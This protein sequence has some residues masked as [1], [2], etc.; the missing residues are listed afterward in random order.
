MLLGITGKKGSGKTT[1]ARIIQGI[2]AGYEFQ[3]LAWLIN[4]AEEDNTKLNFPSSPWREQA[5]SE[6]V[7]LVAA[8]LS[9]YRVE[10]FEDRE[11]K[12]KKLGPEWGYMTVRQLMQKVGE[13]IREGVCRDAWINALFLG[14]ESYQKKVFDHNF[15]VYTSVKK[16]PDWIISDV[17]HLN[18]AGAIR[19]IR[20]YGGCIIQ[21]L[22]NIDNKEDKA[23]SEVEVEKI[24]G[25]VYI[26]N[27][28]EPPMLDLVR[29]V[30]D[31]LH[32]IEVQKKVN[33]VKYAKKAYE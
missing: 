27:R 28:N 5:F 11:F 32:K 7:K 10:D 19:G 2:T 24:R 33:I 16:Y 12:R 31:A 6:K 26:D 25:D 9:G 23:Q 1:V 20:G 22:K 30:Y 14:Y 4:E 17:R 21:M 8:I 29:K 13:S 3:K 15:D 18:E